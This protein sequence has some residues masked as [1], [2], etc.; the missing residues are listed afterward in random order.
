[1]FGKQQTEKKPT[2]LKFESEYIKVVEIPMMFT[3]T[4]WET[5]SDFVATGYTIKSVV[6][7]ETWKTSLVILEKAR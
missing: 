2:G 7:R 5:V 4:A 6:E 3:K 1:M